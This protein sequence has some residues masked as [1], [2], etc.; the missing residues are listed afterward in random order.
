VET[1]DI[2]TLLEDVAAEVITPRFRA[3]AAEQIAEKNP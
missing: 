2:M 3:L 1:D